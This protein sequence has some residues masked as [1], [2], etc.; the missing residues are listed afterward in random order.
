[1]SFLTQD[2]LFR[3]LKDSDSMKMDQSNLRKNFCQI[4]DIISQQST[5][6]HSQISETLFRLETKEKNT[7]DKNTLEFQFMQKH[8][9][10][11]SNDLKDIACFN[12]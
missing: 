4:D 7:H 2:Q 9:D 10:S 5:W 11:L 6:T 8:T 1:M 3:I 12:Q